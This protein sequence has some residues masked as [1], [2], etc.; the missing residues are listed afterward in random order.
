M[1]KLITKLL[2]LTATQP[3]P[4]P[5]LPENTRVYCIGDIHGCYE[6]LKQLTTQIEEDMH[7]FIGRIIVIYLG[8]FIDRGASSKEVI[9]FLINHRKDAVEYVFLR[10]NHEQ[11]LLDFLT[12]DSIAR[13]WLSYGGMATFANYGVHVAKIPTKPDDFKQLQKQF[14]DKLPHEHYQFL[15]KTVLSYSLGCYFFVHAGINPHYALAQQ[16]PEDLLQIRDEF[17]GFK[18]PFEKIIVHGHTITATPE[19]LPNR[20]GIDTG[21]YLSGILTCLVLETDQQRFIQTAV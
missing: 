2:R 8:D 12:E 9:E 18:K 7:G 16:I 3:Y 13:A 15:S 10:G 21:A 11:T 1:K 6:L 4:A 20:I 5:S 19:R 17:I 14:S